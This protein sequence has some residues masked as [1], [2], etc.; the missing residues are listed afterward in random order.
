MYIFRALQTVTA[1]PRHKSEAEPLLNAHA[2][3]L[4]AFHD[5]WRQRRA[6]V[7]QFEQV[8]ADFAASLLP[9]LRRGYVDTMPA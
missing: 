1:S 7:M 2:E 5:Y 6:H 8:F 3:L 4:L 9:S